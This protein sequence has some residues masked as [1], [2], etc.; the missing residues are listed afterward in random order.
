MRNILLIALQKLAKFTIKLRKPEIIAVLGSVGKTNTKEAIYSVL[1]TK[2][3][4][5]K[6]PKSF[7]NELGVPLTIL[8]ISDAYGKNVFLWVFHILKSLFFIFSPRYPKIIVLEFGVSHRNDADYLL[9]IVKPKM[10]VFTAFSDMPVHSENFKD[11]DELFAEKSKAVFSLDKDDFFVFNFDYPKLRALAKKTKAKSFSYGFSDDA[12]LKI[13]DVKLLFDESSGIKIPK[14]TS[15]KI[16]FKGNVVPVRINEI[17][18]G[19]IYASACAVL[20]GDL[21]GVNLVEAS[22]ALLDFHSEKGRIKAFL[23]KKDT[24]VIDDSYNSSPIALFSAIRFIDQIPAKRKVAVLGS[25]LELGRYSYDAHKKMGDLASDQFD[26][27]IFVGKETKTALKEAEKKNKNLFYF[28][29]YDDKIVDVILDFVKKG[30]LIFVKGS[31]GIALDRVVKK[32][33][34]KEDEPQR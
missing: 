21:F 7:N 24:I 4:V 26:L 16:S 10:V 27:L 1:K 3:K 13:E 17:G 22:S 20:V 23:G 6:S 15:F 34:K 18:I 12:D 31:R 11:A 19:N 25:M 5:H 8:G 32:L 29:E 33:L 14:K 2:F 9:R 30:D 28:D